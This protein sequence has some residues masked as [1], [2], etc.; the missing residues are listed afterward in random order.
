MREQWQQLNYISP[1]IYGT[2][3]LP[4]PDLHSQTIDTRNYFRELERAGDVELTDPHVTALNLVWQ[5]VD[6]LPKRSINYYDSF[7]GYL[8]VEPDAIGP[9]TKILDGIYKDRKNNGKYGEFKWLMAKNPPTLFTEE[10]WQNVQDEKNLGGYNN[11]DPVDPR[12]VLYEST[13]EDV[14]EILLKLAATN[15]WEGIEQKRRAAFPEGISP[16]RGTNPF[17]DNSGK[18]WYSLSFN[19]KAGHLKDQ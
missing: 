13:P 1:N 12:I 19:V 3:V 9:A 4:D 14:Q 5:Y 7:R 10:W 2:E 16:I 8:M 15:E 18:T 11:L 17:I 6:Y